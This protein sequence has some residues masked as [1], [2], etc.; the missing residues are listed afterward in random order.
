[1]EF[2]NLALYITPL[3]FGFFLL[4]SS[5]YS[6]MRTSVVFT[7]MSQVLIAQLYL[8]TVQFGYLDEFLAMDPF[9]LF[10]VVTGHWLLTKDTF[11]LWFIFLTFLIQAMCIVHARYNPSFDDFKFK[12]I[13]GLIFLTTFILFNFF[14]STDLLSMYIWFEAILIPFFIIIGIFGNFERRVKASY[15]FFFYTLVGSLGMLAAIVYLKAIYGTTNLSDLA[16][17]VLSPL[18]SNIL[19]FLFFLGIAVKTPLV[20]VHLW[21]PEA[22]VEAPTLGSIILAALLLKMGGFAILR[23]LIPLFKGSIFLYQPFIFTICILSMLFAGLQAMRQTDIK[24]IIALS[25][26]VHMSFSTMGLII[27]DIISIQSALVLMIGHGFISAGLFYCVG[28]YYDRYGIRDLNGISYLW[29]IAPS[30]S[31]FFSFLLF[32]NLSFPGTI[33]YIPEIGIFMKSFDKNP[34]VTLLF[35]FGYFFNT[36]YN[37]WLLSR[38]IFGD[39]P[40]PVFIKKAEDLA[41]YEYYILFGISALVLIHGLAPQSIF[42]G[43][44]GL[45]YYL[46]V[47]INIK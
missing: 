25:S 16:F 20:P 26:I 17:I 46:T 27:P 39:S 33:N 11:N 8:Y 6:G 24:K 44:A 45:A 29:N 42:D 43:F 22:H 1:M 23:I 2:I 36:V 10:S 5:P 18:E 13:S 14:T 37:I 21:L 4:Y 31:F 15:Y 32:A 35:F 47:L 12:N 34:I 41:D 19:F 9:P 40:N 38:V 7:A 30:L 28:C 3:F